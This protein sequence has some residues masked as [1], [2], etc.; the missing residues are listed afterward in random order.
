MGKSKTVNAILIDRYGNRRTIAITVADN[1]QSDSILKSV[2]HFL[3]DRFGVLGSR[4][5]AGTEVKKFH[6]KL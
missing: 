2:I 1:T 3:L 6:W 4:P 5:A